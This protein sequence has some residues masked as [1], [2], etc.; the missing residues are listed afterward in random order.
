MTSTI[1][2]MDATSRDGRTALIVEP[3]PGDA[4]WI[5]AAL[6]E[7]GL[8]VVVS[9]SFQQAQAA[10]RAGPVLLVTA[11]RLAEYNGLHMVLR[12][13][14]ADPQLAAI[15][16]NGDD[17]PVV[18][19][20]AEKLGATFVV[21]K[22]SVREFHAAV[23]RTMLARQPGLEFIRPPFE[24]RTGSR[25]QAVVA[26]YAPERRTTDRRRFSSFNALPGANNQYKDS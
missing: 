23:L 24:R 25:R 12:G 5:A 18:R 4:V 10:L 21:K 15:V 6:S 17:D 16:M 14:S 19:A 3:S 22:I 11:L 7:L 20:E 9:D 26:G 2:T 13:K 8:R 1:V